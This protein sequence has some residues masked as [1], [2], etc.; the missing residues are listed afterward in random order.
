MTTSD[1]TTRTL[2]L[3]RKDNGTL[4]V[5]RGSTSN[6]DAQ[7]A[8]ISSGHS[9]I[10]AF[11]LLNMTDEP[12]DFNNDGRILGWGLRND[13]GVAEEPT[14][15]GIYTVE[16]S[17]DQVR[18][19]GRDV[20][21]DN[22]A[23]EMNF[24]GYMRVP[25]GEEQSPNQGANFGYPD[26]YTAWEPSLL[27][28]FDGDVGE[29]FAINRLT[30]TNNDSYCQS[31]FVAP[32]IP[33]QAHMAPLDI[34][35]NSA[36]SQAWI[37]F[38][39]SWDRSEPSGYKVG[40]VRFDNGEPVEPSTSN[41]ALTDIV[42]NQDNSRCPRNCF[43]PVAMAWDRQG[44][45]FFS[46]D[47]TGEIYVITRAGTADGEDAGVNDAAPESTGKPPSSSPSGNVASWVGAS[48]PA[49]TTVA[50][51]LVYTLFLQ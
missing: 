6:F 32:R 9:Q 47:S 45:L 44:R 38:H 22:P 2:L 42:S 5:N 46:S 51:V 14:R 28:Q 39:G 27:P 10:K 43:R 36:G 37:T 19:D 33:L 34:K 7:A 4:L 15:G 8:D 18:R 49:T 12:Y 16:N 11:S 20:H 35:F 24:L 23:E 17:A 50:T 1:H 31:N 48:N 21:E 41:T 40:T 26:C 13:V 3:S 25:D 29:A 30:D